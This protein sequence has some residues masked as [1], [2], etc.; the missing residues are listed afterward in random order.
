M[1]VDAPEIWIPNE[2]WKKNEI[3][4]LPM[5][6]FETFGSYAG[7]DMSTTTDFTAWANLSEPDND[8][9][10]YLHVDLFCPEDTID[11]RSKEDRVPYR[12]WRD[13]GYIISTPG[14]VIDH[15]Y[16]FDH[17]I[18]N[19]LKYKNIRIEIDRALATNI[20]TE[21]MDAGVEV[22]WFNQGI[23]NISPPT[24]EFEK[25]I[26][27]GKIKYV[28]N[29]AMS[30]ML[31]GCIKIED[32]NENVK[33]HKGRSHQGNKRVDGIIASIMALGGS[34]SMKETP[35]KYETPQS[36]IYI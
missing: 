29:P 6:A 9:I 3:E 2:V 31:S 4:T 23:M 34:I 11:R 24:K 15:K 25:L 20:T 7:L 17:I 12:A 26:Y 32:P 14:N 28:H 13:A 35:S 1:W 8:G 22:S 16:V 36:E 10:R 33:I 18:A 27:Q 5:H 19:R 21:L 30:W